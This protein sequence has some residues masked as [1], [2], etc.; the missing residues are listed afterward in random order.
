MNKEI[1]SGLDDGHKKE[2]KITA[3]K[4]KIVKNKFIRV[5]SSQMTD[6]EFRS[7][8][9]FQTPQELVKTKAAL[10]SALNNMVG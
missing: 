9:P 4:K 5:D 3:K 2:H 10:S 8:D 6:E 1:D 7:M